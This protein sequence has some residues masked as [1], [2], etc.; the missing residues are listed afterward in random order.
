LILLGV[1]GASI[2]GLARL[3]RASFHPEPHVPLF[4]AAA[5][6]HAPSASALNQRYRHAVQ[7]D[8][9]GD[10]AH[11]LA[12]EWLR[13][14]HGGEGPP[15]VVASGGWWQRRSLRQLVGRI[16]GLAQADVPERMSQGEFRSFLAD[17]ERLREKLAA[18]ALRL[19]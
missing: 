13:P 10:Y 8:N 14:L 15:R 18:G 9:L 16:W 6:R 7:E 12:Q 1:L 3:R 5:S 2:Y 19:E 11:I 17:L 4:A